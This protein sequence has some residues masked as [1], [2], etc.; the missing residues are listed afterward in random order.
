MGGLAFRRIRPLLDEDDVSGFFSGILVMEMP[1]TF[2]RMTPKR[3][4][5]SALPKHSIGVQPRANA[6]RVLLHSRSTSDS[7]NSGK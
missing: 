6:T 7:G 3:P 5:H 1:P 2:F 4:S